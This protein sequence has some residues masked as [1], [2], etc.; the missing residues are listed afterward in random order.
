ML[1]VLGGGWMAAGT[2]VMRTLLDANRQ[3]AD[4]SSLCRRIELRGVKCHRKIHVPKVDTK[5]RSAAYRK[6][7]S[8]DHSEPERAVSD[9]S[10]WARILG[11]A[12]A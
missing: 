1:L 3:R 10:S 12:G 8:S 9:R 4:H 5:A 11:E 2:P 7:E 6:Q